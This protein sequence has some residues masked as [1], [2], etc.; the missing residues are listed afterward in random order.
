MASTFHLDWLV[1]VDKTTRDDH[2]RAVA[3]KSEVILRSAQFLGI[4]N[5]T[6]GT[7]LEVRVW[8]EAAIANACVSI[9]W[10]P[11]EAKFGFYLLDESLRERLACVVFDAVP[12]IEGEASLEQADRILD[13]ALAAIR[14]MPEEVDAH[15][16]LMRVRDALNPPSVRVPIRE[17]PRPEPGHES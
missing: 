7:D 4:Q 14:E 6:T 15:E 12:S 17:G 10:E 5:E 2:E 3:E 9:T 16:K 1:P 13:A 11:G 8:V